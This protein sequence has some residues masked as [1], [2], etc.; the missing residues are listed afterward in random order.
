MR[1]QS[2][3]H[4]INISSC[5]G[6][7]ALPGLGIYSASKYALEALSESLAATLNPL[8]IKVTIVEPGFVRN[9]WGSHCVIGSRA[10]DVD[11][12]Q[13]LTKGICGMFA[14]PRGQ[15]CEEIAGVILSIAET[16]VPDLRYQTT[17]N[18][19][20]YIA[21][22]MVDPTGNSTHEQNIHFL[23]RMVNPENS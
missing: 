8:N 19:K 13:K 22:K 2:S 11:Y 15:T 1:K 14:V 21:E 17:E 10:S 4:I 6:V 23:E 9:N 16:D 18:L 12:Y 3:G 20:E 7:N 5:V